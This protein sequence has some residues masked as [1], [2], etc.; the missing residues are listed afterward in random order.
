MLLAL[1]FGVTLALLGVTAG[2][3]VAVTSEH[4][5]AATVVGVVDR[6][7]SLVEYFVNG[8]LRESDLDADRIGDDRSVELSGLLGVLTDRDVSIAR[9]EIRD[10]DG[11]V[12]VS[13]DS[14]L[15]GTAAGIPSGMSI[16][17]EARST[18]VLL[19][20]GTQTEAAGSR[21]NPNRMVQ[22]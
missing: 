14:D 15:V 19:E 16:A 2:A 6:D 9:L 10:V 4:F 5:R 22:E 11:R 3:L 21:A 8:N 20:A 17:L 18:A 12:L 7:A 13:D 1:V